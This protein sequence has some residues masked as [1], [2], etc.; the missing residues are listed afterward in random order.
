MTFVEFKIQLRETYLNDPVFLFE[1]GYGEIKIED[2]LFENVVEHCY[3]VY[4]YGGG[5]IDIKH[6]FRNILKELIKG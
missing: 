1:M 5:D 2:E 4:E 6:L 3:C